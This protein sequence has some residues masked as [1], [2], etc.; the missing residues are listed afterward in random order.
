VVGV[1]MVSESGS[2]GAAG[3]LTGG[4]QPLIDSESRIPGRMTRRTPLI[5]TFDADQR[6]RL[7]T[8]EYA[9]TLRRSTLSIMERIEPGYRLSPFVIR[10]DLRRSPRCASREDS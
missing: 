5:C 4:K 9:G 1:K 8:L 3:G 7:L 10:N 6:G 2:G